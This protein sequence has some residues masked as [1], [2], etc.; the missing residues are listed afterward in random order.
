MMTFIKESSLERKIV[1]TEELRVAFRP[2]TGYSYLGKKNP[3]HKFMYLP[4]KYKNKSAILFY[5]SINPPP[6]G[7]TYTDCVEIKTSWEVGFNYRR[8]V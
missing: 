4:I 2:C 3:N 7:F 6:I 1:I 5:A 8:N